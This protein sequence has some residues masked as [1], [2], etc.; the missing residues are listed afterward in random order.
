LGLH[1]HTE[2]IPQGMDD[3]EGLLTG[4]DSLD[5][6]AV[7]DEASERLDEDGEDGDGDVEES[8]SVLIEGC[9][10][11]HAPAKSSMS[12]ALENE[13][14]TRSEAICVVRDNQGEPRGLGGLDG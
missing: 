6:V 3:R 1:A 10:I 8:D 7:L 2:N 4:A 9:S 13:E 11:S 12:S 14:T 5:G